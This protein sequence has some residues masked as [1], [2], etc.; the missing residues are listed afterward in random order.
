[1]RIDK[2][3]SSTHAKYGTPVNAILFSGALTALAACLGRGALI[4]LVDVGSFCIAVAF[5][6]VSLSLLKL[7]RSQ[8][9]MIR[10]FRLPFA[11]IIGSLAGIGSLF[12]IVAML[13]PMSPVFLVWPLEW[14]ILA[15]LC[16]AGF[17]LW[18]LGK[19][20]RERISETERERLIL[21]EE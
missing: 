2:R 14:A 5:L 11:N 10:P 9:D 7:R 8:P 16:V 1:M 19:K 12:I 17:I 4:A 3:F 20:Q 18:S 6:G 13:I 15:P 21:K